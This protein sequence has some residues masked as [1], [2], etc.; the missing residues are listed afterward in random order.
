MEYSICDKYMKVTAWVLWSFTAT[1]LAQEA[2]FLFRG[3]VV[4]AAS[5]T[6]NELPGGGIAQGSIFTIFGRKIGP[7][8][9]VQVS[10]FPLGKLF[11]GV[12]INVRQRAVQV[13]AI[14]VYVSEGQVN[15]IL[16]SNTPVGDVSLQ[17]TFNGQSS[18]W[19][20]VRVV[21]HAPG[22]FTATGTGRGWAIFQNFISA[23][24][25]PL[26][27][28]AISAKPGQVG[29][30]WLTGS[31]AISGAD[32]DT[33]PVGDL[34]Y[35]VE[36][37]V[38]GR[39]VT[40][41][42]YSGRAPGISALDQYVFYIPDDAPSGCFVPVYVKVA[43]A[44]SNP[45][46]LAISSDGG[47]CADAHNPIAAGM[48]QGGKIVNAILS[49]GSLSGGQ[50]LGIDVDVTADK[51][52]ARAMEERGGQFAFDPFLSLPPSGTCSSYGLK[53]NVLDT[54]F[55]S[56]GAGRPLDLGTLTVTAAAGSKPLTTLQ[57]GIY[58]ATL[59]G[60]FPVKAPFLDSGPFAFQ[61]SGGADGRSFSVPVGPGTVLSGAKLDALV[62]LDRTAGA[63]V[64]WTAAAGSAVLIASNYLQSVDASG[65]VVCVSQ[66]GASSMQ[67]PAYVTANLPPSGD[68]PGQSEGHIFFGA[69]PVVTQTTTPDQVRVFAARQDVI[70]VGLSS[71]R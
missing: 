15:A 8:T 42:L 43:G 6:S 7:T 37:Y 44:V 52:N 21:E 28:G 35:P 45:T 57:P 13:S 17:I 36:I 31:G 25:Q 4:N 62:A 55:Q 48:I 68:N 70:A 49:R 41:K 66:T 27:S 2:P 29:T 38:G 30:L 47:A 58:D 59:G 26:N 61:A 50:F 67:I 69:L 16:P 56:A 32:G 1:A 5:F 24:N 51:A 46:T 39:P 34:P 60:G 12:A 19:V 64:T 63:T 3:G 20:P 14:P 22:M 65:V 23:A 33:P 10:S 53:G 54:G 18:N 11:S 40:R 71:V 9:A